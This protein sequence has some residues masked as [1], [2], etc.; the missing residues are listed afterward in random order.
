MGNFYVNLT[1]RTTN[2]EEIG[3]LLAGRDAVISPVLDGNLV[4]V[5]DKEAD[6]QA[7]PLIEALAEEISRRLTTTVFVVLNHDDDVL[8][9]A[10]YDR[11]EQTYL[12]NSNP[13]FFEGTAAK[14]GP[15]GGDA[16][17]L[18]RSFGSKDTEAVE[19][20]LRKPGAEADDGYTFA[21]RRHRDLMRALGATSQ[22]FFVGYN[23]LTAG[24]YPPDLNK[25]DFIEVTAAP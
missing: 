19:A 2:R 20:V 18:C 13:D 21:H 6:Y 8:L 5:Y 7:W 12:Y 24:E 1:A 16:D 17:L 15:A 11:G 10:L 14:R 25:D 22:A 3:N 4:V 9:C 23:Y